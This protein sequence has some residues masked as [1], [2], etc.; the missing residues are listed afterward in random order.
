MAIRMVS[1]P[2][3]TAALAAIPVTAGL[4]CRPPAAGTPRSGAATAA[5]V[6]ANDNRRPAGVVRNGVLHLQLEIREGD[7]RP[8]LDG[9]VYRVLAFAE[10]DQPLAN[11]GPLIRVREG[12]PIEAS[13]RSRVGDDIVIHGMHDRSTP[14]TPLRVPGHGTAAVRFRSGP[15]GTHYYWGTRG[16]PLNDREGN[17]SQLTGALVVDPA[18][19]ATDD[20]IF[21]VGLLVSEA[22]LYSWVINGRSW[23]DTE[24]VTLRLG[25]RVR[26][27]WINATGHRHP[28]HLHGHYFRVTSAGDNIRDVPRDPAELAVTHT[29]QRGHTMSMLWSPERTGNWL[30][31]CHILSHV[32]PDNR[33]P[34]DRWYEEYAALPHDRH[35]A[36]LVLGLH[37]E[38]RPSALSAG[39]GAPAR[40]IALR[41]GERSGVTYEIPGLKGPGLGY[42]VDGGPI[43]APGPPIVLERS[44]PVAI[45]I[46]NGISHATSVHWHGIELE[47]YYDG[48]PHFGGDSRARTP[49][50]A[51]GGNFVARFSPPRAGTFAYHTHF[52]DYAQLSTG[53]YGALIVLEKGQRLDPA[54]DHAFVVSRDGLDDGRDPVLL[55]GAIEPPPMTWRA[56]V[57]HRLRFIGMMPAVLGRV[58]LLREG[59]PVTW[60]AIAKDGADLPPQAATARAADFMLSPGETFD[61]EMVPESGEMRLEVRL[62]NTVGQQA[63]TRVIVRP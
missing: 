48:V 33:L 23:P 54:V 49:Y 8:E 30:F 20:R 36:G 19:G 26:W 11:P 45:T 31:H 15:S 62:D 53:L 46:Q 47:S 18:G 21:V 60:R 58:R 40:A 1:R 63:S 10:G 17:D 44:K 9:P 59:Q 14:D 6:E 29:L 41:V 55:N 3:C 22:Q 7:W 24:R 50:I 61:F 5:A 57:K 52:N 42:G 56:G 34:A 13:I 38:E 51:P 4:A 16:K 39:D 43:S 28:M 27:R 37:V 32:A 25:D 35:M 2:V 12:T